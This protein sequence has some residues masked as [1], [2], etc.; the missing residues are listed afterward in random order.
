MSQKDTEK[1]DDYLR[2]N[3]QNMIDTAQTKYYARFS[4]FLDERQQEIAL[5]VLRQQ[6]FENY[7]FFGGAE[8]CERQMLGVFPEGETPDG[9]LFPIRP[10]GIVSRKE[11]LSHRDCLGSLLGLNIKRTALGDIL[12]HDTRAVLF[13]AEEVEP[14]IKSNLLRVGRATVSFYEPEPSELVRTQTFREKT[15]TVSS[16]RLDCVVSFLLGKSRSAAAQIISSGL[17]M[18]NRVPVMESSKQLSGGDQIVVRGFGKCFLD[19]EMKPTKKGR[20]FIKIN[21]LL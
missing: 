19:E 7:L 3:V 20:L 11:P 5:G 8:G 17:V 13:A 1:Q 18:V 12:I 14:F 4:S 2:S 9:M 21:Q 15:G 6:H 10:L 16:L